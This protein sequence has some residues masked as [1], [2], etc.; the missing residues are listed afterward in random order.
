[1]TCSGG[2][3]REAVHHSF[4]AF[5]PGQGMRSPLRVRELRPRMV[6]ISDRLIG[7]LPERAEDGV[8]DLL[9]DYAVGY[10]ITAIRQLIG[11]PELGR[12]RGRSGARC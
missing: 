10:S 2:R 1:M 7:E 11:I 9:K 8:V 3:T 6:E 5:G 12:V 4:S